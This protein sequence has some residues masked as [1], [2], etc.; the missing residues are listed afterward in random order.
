MK[1]SKLSQLFL[2]SV[3]GLGVASLLTAC[4]LVTVDYVFVADS[5]GNT[6]SSPGQI[7]VFA[8]DSQS[9]ALRTGAPT[10]ATGGAQP[11]ALALTSNYFHLYVANAGS[12]NVVHF[13]IDGHGNLTKQDTIMLTAAPVALAVNSTNSFLY[14]VSGGSSPT[15]TEYPLSSSGTIG[16]FTA[17]EPFSL[18]CT[19]ASA[20]YPSD[21]IVPTAATVIAN[22][23][24][25][26]IAAYDSSAYNP[27]GAVT[28]T[29]NPG[30]I[31]GFA[32]GANGALTAPSGNCSS[33]V[34][35]DVYK[36]GIKPSGITGDP[37]SRFIYVTD[38]ASN[39]LIGYS[40]QNAG[41]LSFMVNGPFKTG[42]EPSGVAVDPRGV[43]LYVT[44]QLDSN[45]SSFSI[46]LPTGT[47]ST[48]INVVTGTSSGTDV[49]PVA[50]AIDPALGRFIYTA[51]RLGNS[52]SG[53]MLNP[54]TGALNI[55]Q[56][57]PYPTSGANPS[58][59]AIVP[60]GNHSIQAVTP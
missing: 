37:V 34:A 12:N 19:S 29:A 56:A 13:S 36:A 31:F 35:Y 27:S 42:N 10:V 20:S 43:Y 33:S 21:T 32:V 41:T 17:T 60:H 5:A 7:E 15:L 26:Y 24:N 57:T 50:L 6:P 40:I 54:D 46:A 44:N 55:T 45:V 38:F 52:V 58:A 18:N 1:F 59:L 2:V 9:G 28:S 4:Q 14:V 47:P 22:A 51:N 23:N 25:V 8:V 39:E 48:V 49:Q 30:W 16:T 53:L 11:V 3:I